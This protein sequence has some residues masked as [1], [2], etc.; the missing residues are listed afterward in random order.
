VVYEN[1]DRLSQVRIPGLVSPSLTASIIGWIVSSP[2]LK[3]QV[4]FSDCPLSVFSLLE[5]CIFNFFS[6][7]AGPILTKSFLGKG[8][9]DC[10]NEGQPPSSRWNNSK[11]VKIHWNLKKKSSSSQPAGH[12][13]SIKLGTI[14]P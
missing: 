3:A 6:R 4:S 8:D 13:L 11:S 1:V 10:T 5:F 7:A 14:H 12:A 2:E 9:S